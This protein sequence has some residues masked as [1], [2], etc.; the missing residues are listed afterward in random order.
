MKQSIRFFSLGILVSTVIMGMAYWLG[1]NEQAESTVTMDEED[2]I[3]EIE[4][5]HYNVLTEE[6]L[7]E[8]INEA[9]HSQTKAASTEESTN[10]TDDDE[11]TQEEDESLEEENETNTYTLVIEEGISS[12]DISQTLEQQG[13]IENAESF[14]I[15]L[16]DRKLT[17]YIQ[18]GEFELNENM[19]RDEVADT[20]TR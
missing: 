17:Q 12:T 1:P 5:S 20:I 19:N 10:E 18:I 2:M 15:Y 16:S 13:I 7:Q 3:S 4:A 8:K 9:I 6:Q 11:Q 14:D